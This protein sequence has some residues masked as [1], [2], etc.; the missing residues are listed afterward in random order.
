MAKFHSKEAFCLST[1]RLGSFLAAINAL[2]LQFSSE[3]FDF[4]IFDKALQHAEMLTGL[5]QAT[6]AALVQTDLIYHWLHIVS[7]GM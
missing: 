3:G 4:F 5:L 2:I 7:L 6:E 1:D